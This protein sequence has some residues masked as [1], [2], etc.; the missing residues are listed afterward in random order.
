MAGA[1][2]ARGAS[3]LVLVSA[4]VVLDRPDSEYQAV[5]WGEEG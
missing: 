2:L 5:C 3:L 4:T 1:R